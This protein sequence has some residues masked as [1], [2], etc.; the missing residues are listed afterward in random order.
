MCQS[1]HATHLCPLLWI[2]ILAF[3]DD[4]FG[5]TWSARG[6]GG[7]GFLKGGNEGFGVRCMCAS[8]MLIILCSRGFGKMA[9]NKKEERANR[10][11]EKGGAV[12]CASR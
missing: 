10:I 4:L 9:K 12:E 6:K 7:V 1:E 11:K 2:F 8:P 5:W 3:C